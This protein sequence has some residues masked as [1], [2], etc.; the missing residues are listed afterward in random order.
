MTQ[1]LVLC[2]QK[3]RPILNNSL[4]VVINVRELV[5]SIVGR[6]QPNTIGIY[7]LPLA[8]H[9]TSRSKKKTNWLNVRICPNEAISLPLFQQICTTKLQPS[10]LIWEKVCI[11]IY[12]YTR[13]LYRTNL[14]QL[15]TLPYINI[16]LNNE[17][18]I[19]CHDKF[20]RFSDQ[21]LRS[22]KFLNFYETNV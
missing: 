16:F 2:S 21:K 19:T 8:K 17:V 18:S 5:G 4:G 1:L 15:G 11:I 22:F 20:I 7:F 13:H 14:V 9:T 10:V 12:I 3:K 6:V